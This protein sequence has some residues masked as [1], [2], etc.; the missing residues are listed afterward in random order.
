MFKL[1]KT[2]L[3]LYDALQGHPFWQDAFLAVCEKN[4]RKWR[5][6]LNDQFQHDSN[7]CFVEDKHLPYIRQL[8]NSTEIKKFD[9]LFF[10]VH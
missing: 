2:Q 10:R 8:R 9:Q 6:A 5:T 4:G 7:V 1:N 3:K